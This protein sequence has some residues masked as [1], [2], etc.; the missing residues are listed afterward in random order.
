MRYG[1]EGVGWER[2]SE[3]EN[4]YAKPANLRV[5]DGSLWS[6][7]NNQNWHTVGSAINDYYVVSQLAE[8]N[9]S[10][11]VRRNLIM[12]EVYFAYEE[13]GTPDEVVPKLNYTAEEAEVVSEVSQILTDYVKSARA[14][15]ATGAMDPNSDA[16]WQ[17]YLDALENQGYNDYIEV[18][19]A[20]YSRL[21]SG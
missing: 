10:W 5:L 4:F 1:E 11:A 19:Q 17:S 7:Q 15:F 12:Y 20:A 3:G 21:I 2:I 6:S 13:T 8:I 16:D 9:D 18:A 14:L